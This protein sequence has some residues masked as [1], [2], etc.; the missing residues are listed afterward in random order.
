M[1]ACLRLLRPRLAVKAHMINRQAGGTIGHGGQ[2]A[3]GILGEAPE[4]GGIVSWERG[5]RDKGDLWPAREPLLQPRWDSGPSTKG[6]FPGLLDW[7]RHRIGN[8]R[9]WHPRGD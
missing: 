3:P 2:P 9:S 5:R 8:A 4:E 6:A 7:G 1:M